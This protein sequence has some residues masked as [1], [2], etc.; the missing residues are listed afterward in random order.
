VPAGAGTV[1]RWHSGRKAGTSRSECKA[2]GGTY[3]GTDSGRSGKYSTC[4][5]EDVDG[6]VHVDDHR[7]GR[8]RGTV[9]L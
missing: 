2:A 9:D 4:R 7:G 6:K 1:V 3:D 5:Y 8:Y